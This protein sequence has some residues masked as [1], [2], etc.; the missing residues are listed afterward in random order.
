[1]YEG[2][3]EHMV[4]GQKLI[5]LPQ[6]AVIWKEASML[7]AADVHLGKTA[8]FRKEGIAV[9]GSMAFAD[10][11]MLEYLARHF[12]LQNML[13]LGDLFHTRRNAEWEYFMNWRARNSQLHIELVKG[14][15]DLVQDRL[16][17]EAG[18]KWHN[19]TLEAGPFL[20]TH[21]PFPEDELR[22][23]PFYVMSGHVHPGIR[24]SGK[25]KQSVNLCC[26][27]FGQRQAILPAFGTF[28]G[29]FLLKIKKSDKVYAVFEDRVMPVS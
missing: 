28:T 3:T 5:L 6:K 29:K 13:F 27:Y 7:I 22:N 15:H 16:L 21:V 11:N 8:H 2:F 26:F 17:G 24:M 25:A 19:D 14:N 23:I 20:F 9:P 18:I 12:G 4:C 10:L 1:M